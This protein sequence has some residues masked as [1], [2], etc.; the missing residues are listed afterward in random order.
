[1]S[2]IL[3]I[4]NKPKKFVEK[5]FPDYKKAMKEQLQELQTPIPKS[6]YSFRREGEQLSYSDWTF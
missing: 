2:Y 4:A 5:L 1:M 3:Y 6:L